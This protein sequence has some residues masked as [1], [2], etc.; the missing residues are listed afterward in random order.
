MTVLVEWPHR[1]RDV[2]RSVLPS[3]LDT[4]A[5]LSLSR[6]F[7][8]FYRHL[9]RVLPRQEFGFLHNAFESFVAQDWKGLVRGQHRY[10]SSATRRNS[11][12]MPAQEAVKTARTTDR[13]ILELARHGV[14]KARF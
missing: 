3:D 1:L 11:Q 14:V 2:L 9:F 12:W 4:P 8:N 5:C 13:R 6:V 10:F 7:G